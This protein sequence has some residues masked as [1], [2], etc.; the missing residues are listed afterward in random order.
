M[1][2]THHAGLATSSPFYSNIYLNHETPAN[3]HWAFLKANKCLDSNLLLKAQGA[4]I[5]SH[6]NQHKILPAHKEEIFALKKIHEK[7]SGQNACLI[8]CYFSV[9]SIK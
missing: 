6:L 5:L 3:K 2:I 7:D 4:L 8:C 9:T 1:D